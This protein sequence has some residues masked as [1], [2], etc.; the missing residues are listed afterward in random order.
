[1]FSLES[2]QNKMLS[3]PSVW[4]PGELLFCFVFFLI[5]PLLKLASLFIDVALLLFVPT[6]TDFVLYFLVKP[7]NPEEVMHR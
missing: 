6:K 3:L 2:T 5:K 4:L 1:M 7:S